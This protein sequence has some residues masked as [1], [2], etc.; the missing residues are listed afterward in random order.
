[1]QYFL[2]LI[3]AGVLMAAVLAYLPVQERVP[4]AAG[5]IVA[6][7]AA[8]FLLRKYY[9]IQSKGDRVSLLPEREQELETWK[10]DDKQLHS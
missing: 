9:P 7:I 8:I 1:M 5:I 2:S 6:I 10:N 3:I 4:V